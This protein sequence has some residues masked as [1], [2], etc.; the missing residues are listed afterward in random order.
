MMPDEKHEPASLQTIPWMSS[1]AF[2][3]KKGVNKSPVGLVI[4][5]NGKTH[6][7]ALLVLALPTNFGL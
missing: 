4:F 1:E 3:P 2:F 6:N 5:V 7:Y